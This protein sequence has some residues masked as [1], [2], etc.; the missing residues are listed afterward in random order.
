MIETLSVINI[1]TSD[2]PAAA[3]YFAEQTKGIYNRE[4]WE[5]ILEWVWIDN[6]NI[7][8]PD[9]ITGW[10]LVNESG[11]IKGLLGQIPVTYSF[12]G[13]LRSSS[14]VTSWY[15]DEEVRT[16]SMELFMRFLK[17]P[18]ILMNNTPIPSV[19]NLITK[20][21]KFKRAESGWFVTSYLFPLNVAG[22]FFRYDR[23]AG[24]SKRRMA[25]LFMG[26]V[27]KIP[28]QIMFL[29]N[30]INPAPS[31]LSVKEVDIPAADTDQWFNAYSRNIACTFNRSGANYRWLFR[32]PGFAHLFTVFEIR[33]Q[34]ALQGYLVFKTRH[35]DNFSYIE[36]IDEAVL[37]LP[38]MLMKKI[39]LQIY[40]QLNRKADRQSLLIMRSNNDQFRAVFRSM[41]GVPV[42]KVEKSYYKT[43]LLKPDDQPLLTSV[44]G[45]SL[46]F[47]N[48]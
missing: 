26:A 2:I 33:Y 47:F 29:A 38:R 23:K 8:S 34:G 27:L 42:K 4:A 1:S 28:Q 31:G 19:E 44:D 48:Y 9:T 25:I 22:S 46:F 45:D 36:L 43:N 13:E 11:V 15:V 30:A 5:K 35:A 7:S 39:I 24:W 41:A 40:K 6:P 32:Q 21:F 12:Y 18:G 16:R 10:A 37:T 14:W 17:Q 3:D 20:L